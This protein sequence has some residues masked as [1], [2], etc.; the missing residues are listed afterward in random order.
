MKRLVWR[1]GDILTLEHSAASL[2][3]PQRNEVLLK[4]RAVGICGTD[5]HILKG[6]LSLAKPPLVLGHEVSGEIAAVG[7]N[8]DHLR[9]GDRV[10]L[11]AV[12]GCG[13]CDLCN[14]DSVQFCP[15]GFEFGITRDGGCQ[16]YLVVPKQNVHRIADSVSFE[17][18]AIL[19]M[20]VYNAVRK[21][22]IEAADRVLVLGA[23]PIGLIACQVARILGAGHVTLSDVLI[24]RLDAARAIG[25]GDAHLLAEVNSEPVAT[26]RQGTKGYDVVIDCA[27]TSQSAKHALS[28]VR[29]AGRVLL[30]GVYE[31]PVNDLDLNQIVLKDLIVFGAQSDRNGWEEVIELVTS[32]TLNLNSLITHR[33]PLEEGRRALELVGRREESVIK[34]VL[35][36]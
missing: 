33:F 19:D 3:D 13:R 16:E 18:A 35:V 17:E 28:R 26:D 10:T 5:I 9:V 22:G 1:G 14:R 8:V 29:P 31:H 15:S 32:G 25:I 24:G 2:P 4:I 20:E 6:A 34:A 36:L 11:D 12:I 21:C 7:A 27:G 30:Y 23:G